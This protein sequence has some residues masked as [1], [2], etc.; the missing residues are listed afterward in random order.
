MAGDRDYN[1]TVLLVDCTGFANNATTLTGIDKA[2]TTAKTLTCNGNAK[3]STALGY[4][5]LVFDGTGDFISFPD[6]AD[7]DFTTGAGTI[8]AEVYISG[9][10][11]LDA[12]NLRNAC[13]FANTADGNT[14]GFTFFILGSSTTTG[15]GLIFDPVVSGVS[16]ARSLTGITISQGALH[17]FAVSWDSTG[18]Y[19]AVD[20]TV[21]ATTALPVNVLGG[22]APKIGRQQTTSYARDLNGYVKYVRIYNGVAKYKANF[23]LPVSY[24]AFSGQINY[25]LTEALAATQ[26]RLIASKISDGTLAKT[27]VI[28][29]SGVLDMP[30][31]DTV[32]IT[33]IPVQGNKWQAGTIYA[34]GDLV[35]PTVAYTHYFKRVA[36]TGGTSGTTEPTWVNTIGDTTTD[37]GVWNNCWECIALLA[38]S[39]SHS[40]IVPSDTSPPTVTFDFTLPPVAI[41]YLME[42]W[43]PDNAAFVYWT[44]TTKNLSPSATIPTSIVA[45]L[46]NKCVLLEY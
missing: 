11:A 16:Y 1:K 3:I 21:T 13:I 19:F 33:A 9:N 4:P 42:A 34:A 2:Y 6:T 31:L 7:V 29:A 17:H 14:T 18:V 35:F 40:P 10:S 24:P 25:T 44:D 28:T 8:E 46:V 38:D 5:A 26:F 43:S 36:G 32:S 22:T 45:N 30:L 39:I 15:T 23:S 12:A 20:G 37:D 41:T 27:A